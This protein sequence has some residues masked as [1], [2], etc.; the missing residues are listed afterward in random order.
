MQVFGGHSGTFVGKA[1]R[2]RL[3]E[4]D[5]E[6]LVD[7]WR[8]IERQRRTRIVG[9]LAAPLFT[10]FDPT[11]PTWIERLWARFQSWRTKRK[12]VRA[13]LRQ[14]D[15]DAAKAERDFEKAQQLRPRLP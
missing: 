8:R 12:V 7:R 13:A 4:R 9:K 14:S 6:P 15:V 10:A 11:G 5:K 3:R 1:N 2:A